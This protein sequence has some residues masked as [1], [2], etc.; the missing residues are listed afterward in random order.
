MFIA[1][2]E[3]LNIKTNVTFGRVFHKTVTKVGHDRT[4]IANFLEI[5]SFINEYNYTP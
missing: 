3:G 5:Q 4:Q 2:Y 1:R